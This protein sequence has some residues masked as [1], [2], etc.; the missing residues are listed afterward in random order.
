[1]RPRRH[2]S[3]YSPRDLLWPHLENIR[4]TPSPGILHS[5]SYLL[6][7]LRIRPRPP[8]TPADLLSTTVKQTLHPPA[9]S[10][11]HPT[12]ATSSN[13]PPSLHPP[14]PPSPQIRRR[15]QG[16]SRRKNVTVTVMDRCE[17]CQLSDIDISPAAFEHLADLDEGRVGVEWSWVDPVSSK[18]S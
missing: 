15:D 1:M 16:H 12:T 2:H 8:S 18:L 17:G 14:P 5:L 9:H 11:P 4:N 6:H 10:N 3:E 7:S 13:K